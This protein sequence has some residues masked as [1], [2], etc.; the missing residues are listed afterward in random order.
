MEPDQE[1]RKE[2]ADFLS[3]MG[4]S[5]QADELINAEKEADT[6]FN[7]L[8]GQIEQEIQES[9]NVSLPAGF[10]IGNYQITHQIGQGGMAHVYLAARSDGLFDQQV[11]VKLLS[12][13][14]MTS[15]HRDQFNRE[16]ELLASLNH[17][18]IAKIFDGG[19]LKEGIHYLVMEYVAGQPIDEYVS[20]KQLTTKEIIQIVIKVLAGLQHAHNQ[21]ILHRDL[22]PANILI[23]ESGDPVIVDFGIGRQLDDS[24]EVRMSSGTLRYLPP[25]AMADASPGISSDLFQIGL[26]LMEL[27]FEHPIPDTNRDEVFSY[28]TSWTFQAP[29]SAPG[30]LA[31]VLEKALQKKPEDR[32]QTATELSLDLQRYLELKPTSASKNGVLHTAWLFVRRNTA[33]VALTAIIVVIS[34]GSAIFNQMQINKTRQ[35]K[36]KL[37]QSYTFLRNIFAANDPTQNNGE[38]LSAKDLLQESE[39]KIAEIE[40]PEIK[41]YS[42]NLLG[43]LY[44]ELGLWK[45]SG[46]L[47]LEA[48]ELLEPLNPPDIELANLHNNLGGYYRNLSELAKADSSMTLAVALLEPIGDDYP[49]MLAG[50]YQD[51]GYVKFMKGDYDA[52]VSLSQQAIDLLEKARKEHVKPNQKYTKIAPIELAHAYNGLSSNQREL[53]QNDQALQS[54]KKAHQLALPYVSEDFSAFSVALNN[55]AL[56][57]NRLG[58]Y[59]QQIELLKQKLESDLERYALENPHVLTTLANLGSAYYKVED[60]QKSDSLTLMAYEVYKKKYGATNQY[61]IVT[62]YNLGNSKYNQGKHDEA[63]Q[64]FKQVLQADISNLGENHP[65]IAGDYISLGHVQYS[66]ENWDEARNYYEKALDIYVSNFGEQ[67]QKVSFAHSLLGELYV[68]TSNPQKAIEHYQKATEISLEVL[69]KNHHRYHDYRSKLDSLTK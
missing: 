8:I 49:I 53:S 46:P 24:S 66:K 29:A 40:D 6:Y 7:T 37:E 65:Y 43:T 60:Y 54:A 19:I 10:Q 67:H 68:D 50:A 35:E 18:N 59:E 1:H 62:L 14:K 30:N 31:P 32:Y 11:A 52:G 41:A 13:D 23:N 45:E 57:Y 58:N 3:A 64:Y 25:E 63:N 47:F 2:W 38:E 34:V 22:K 17:P 16:R 26:V 12:A 27:L 56:A 61:T 42:L 36:A 33:L 55:M 44:A 5:Q 48:L 28:L 69:G 21:F 4:E 20:E 9:L 39:T 51:L 15:S